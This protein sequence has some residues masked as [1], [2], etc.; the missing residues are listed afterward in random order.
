MPQEVHLLLVQLGL[1]ELEDEL[2]LLEGLEDCVHQRN[3]LLSRAHTDDQTVIDVGECRPK[4]NALLHLVLA[5]IRLVCR[6]CA[7]ESR[8]G[9]RGCGP[10]IPPLTHAESV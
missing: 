8:A 5:L 7:V 10:F 4:G 9:R 1:G 6:R 3:V 2:V